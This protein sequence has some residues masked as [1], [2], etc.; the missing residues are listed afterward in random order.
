MI[1]LCCISLAVLTAAL[2]GC[3]QQPVVP[4]AGPDA[5]DQLG[6]TGR[7][8]GVAGTPGPNGVWLTRNYLAYGSFYDP[9]VVDDL[10][11]RMRNVYDVG[12][13]FLNVDRTG[14][15][16]RLINPP[17]HMSDFLNNVASWES[18][19]GGRMQLFAWV[20]GATAGSTTAMD[21]TDPTVRRAVIEECQKLVSPS[22]P[23]SYVAQTQRPFDGI[24]IDFEPS[25]FDE[26]RFRALV[27]LMEEL[28]AG[29]AE[30]G[31]SDV[32]LSVAAHK[33][34]TTNSYQWLQ[35]FYYDMASRVD[36]LASMTYNSGSATGDDYQAWMRNQ[37]VTVLQ[38]VSGQAWNDGNHPAPTNGV[39]V[40]FGLPAYPAGTY[41]DVT[42][43][44]I[45]FGAEGLRDGIAALKSAQDPSVSYLSGAAV[46]LHTKGIADD[47]YA[48][49]DTEWWWFGHHW[50]RRW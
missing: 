26:I 23:G 28:R 36:L 16:G 34:G 43:E 33:Y 9:A 24:Q 21:L 4:D 18:R 13:W 37:L 29:L 47:G 3:G 48:R 45:A 31:R 49:W 41:H 5:G 50:L 15:D 1:R 40:L 11:E 2:V 6:G 19:T 44:T 10:A 12:Y 17:T 38:G 46:Y 7:D 35:S 25:G 42:A 30:V 22:V 39:K 14:A 27:S 8:G 20:N 32:L